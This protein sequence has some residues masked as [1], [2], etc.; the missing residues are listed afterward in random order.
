MS[1]GCVWLRVG[2]LAGFGWRG[3]WGGLAA[4]LWHL[5]H[6]Q[7]DACCVRDAEGALGGVRA[8]LLPDPGGPGGGRRETGGRG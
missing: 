8:T 3:R 2:P 6:T 1:T 4:R 5:M 7:Q